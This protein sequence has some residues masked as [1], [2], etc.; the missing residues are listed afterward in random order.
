MALVATLFTFWLLGGRVAS[1]AGAFG[2]FLLFPLILL[3]LVFAGGGVLSAA[4]VRTLR[5]ESTDLPGRDTAAFLL[6][7]AAAPPI[8]GAF[9]ITQVPG[10][11]ISAF[12]AAFAIGAAGVAALIGA[13]GGRLVSAGCHPRY[14]LA[15]GIIVLGANAWYLIEFSVVT[16]ELGS[17]MGGPGQVLA[18]IGL[19]V[20]AF[21]VAFSTV[22]WYQLELHPAARTE[23]SGPAD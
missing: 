19:L 6:H 13:T 12:G 7:A 11:G 4:L 22:A 15:A 5:M 14:T 16:G 17:S 8:W 2:Q 23:P 10:I 3:L 9:I 20:A 1:F 18:L 21:P